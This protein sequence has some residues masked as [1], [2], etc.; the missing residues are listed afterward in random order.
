MASILDCTKSVCAA[1]DKAKNSISSAEAA[2]ESLRR[3]ATAN[4]QAAARQIQAYLDVTGKVAGLFNCVATKPA[5]QICTDG[6]VQHISLAEALARLNALSIAGM[7]EDHFVATAGQTAFTLGAAAPNP[8]QLEV[9]LNG[10]L[11]GNP[12]DYTIA[13]STLTFAIGL[14]AG[15]QVETRRFTV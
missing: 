10:S 6:T 7:A 14:D 5:G 12:R 15:D 11:Q 3:Q 9:W 1:A 8:A 13:G 2:L 4:Q